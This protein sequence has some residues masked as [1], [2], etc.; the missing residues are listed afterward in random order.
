MLNRCISILL[1]WVT[2]DIS[3]STFRGINRLHI[4]IFYNGLGYWAREQSQCLELLVRSEFYNG[5]MSCLKAWFDQWRCCVWKEWILKFKP[6]TSLNI[7]SSLF[8]TNKGNN[9][10]WGATTSAVNYHRST[11]TIKT[12]ART[13]DINSE[14]RRARLYLKNRKMCGLGCFI[15]CS[16]FLYAQ[17]DGKQSLCY[18]WDEGVIP[19]KINSEQWP[20]V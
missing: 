3:P 20:N 5:N 6:R 1:H 2:R 11:T 16:R 15:N 12:S 13:S 8:S 7:R 19:A 9:E 10:K 4:N 17:H 14:D 18:C